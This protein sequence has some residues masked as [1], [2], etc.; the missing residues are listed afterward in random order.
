MRIGPVLLSLLLLTGSA[1]LAG[2]GRGAERG[3]ERGEAGPRVLP[4]RAPAAHRFGTRAHFDT[5]VLRMRL[6]GIQPRWPGPRMPVAPP[7]R[8]VDCERLKCVALTFDDG[9]GEQTD[10][11]LDV[12][13]AHHARATFFMLGEMI[14]EGTREF[15]RRMVSEGHELGNHSWDHASLAGLSPEALKRELGRTQDIVRQVAGVRMSVMRPPYGA[16]N[17]EVAAVTKQEGLAQI[18]WAVD[19]LDWRDRNASVVAK[20]CGD[21]KPGDIVLMHDI[22]PTTVQALP[23]LLDALDH[24]GFT[25][26]TVSEL[27]GRLVPGKEYL[28]R[29]PTDRGLQAKEARPGS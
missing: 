2:C 28:S 29:P 18:L 25:Y 5:G 27:L 7:P 9:P 13:A 4:M 19:T 14:T 11:V 26:V 3:A 21:A 22:H 16:T 23:H 8:Q 24:K 10:K 12:L 17:H 20:R 6:A 15:V 1:E